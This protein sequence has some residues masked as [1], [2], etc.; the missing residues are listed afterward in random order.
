M[1][2]ELFYY[3]ELN[4]HIGEYFSEE[5]WS[6]QRK[7]PTDTNIQDPTK[8]FQ[9]TTQSHIAFYQFFTATHLNA[10]RQQKITKHLRKPPPHQKNRSKQAER[11]LKESCRNLKRKDDN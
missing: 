7:T 3:S 6:T 10:N 11:N 9:S 4:Y 1:H 8:N 5:K 2:F